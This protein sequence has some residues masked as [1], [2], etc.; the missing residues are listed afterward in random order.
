MSENLNLNTDLKTETDNKNTSTYNS[1]NYINDEKN[2][3]NNDDDN[4]KDESSNQNIDNEAV[5]SIAN[6]IVESM[7]VN[8]DADNADHSNNHYV[9][10]DNTINKNI[11]DDKIQNENDNDDNINNDSED[12]DF[13]FDQEALIK[14]LVGNAV[15][16]LENEVENDDND[17][18]NNNNNNNND[19]NDDENDDYNNVEKSRP[20]HLTERDVEEENFNSKDI[21]Q[22]KLD[23]ISQLQRNKIDQTGD[24][25]DLEQAI[26]DAFKQ[27]FDFENDEPPKEPLIYSDNRAEKN[28]LKGMSDELEVENNQEMNR[29]VNM[30]LMNAI[31]EA[32]E[33][34][35]GGIENS[36]EKASNKLHVENQ[37]RITHNNSIEERDNTDTMMSLNKGIQNS[38]GF[39][40][41]EGNLEISNN[42]NINGIDSEITESIHNSRN[43][44][45]VKINLNAEDELNAA[46]ADALKNTQHALEG[47]TDGNVNNFITSQ[48]VNLESFYADMHSLVKEAVSETQNDNVPIKK[49]NQFHSKNFDNN[50]LA[51]VIQDINLNDVMANALK[52]TEKLNDNLANN[53][54]NNV[55]KEALLSVPTT[56]KKLNKKST[57]KKRSS[58]ILLPEK[59]KINK[60]DKR[61]TVNNDISNELTKVINSA[62][63]DTGLTHH[64]SKDL[65]TE[66]VDDFEFEN[67]LK[68]V[69]NGVIEHNLAE[70]GNQEVIQQELEDSS[71]DID[72][73]DYNWDAIMDNAFE[74]AME[75]PEDLQISVGHDDEVVN[76]TKRNDNNEITNNNINDNDNADNN[77]YHNE[78]NENFNANINNLNNQPITYIS[79]P[80][81]D[82]LQGNIK[83]QKPKS[84]DLQE[85]EKIPIVETVTKMLE[86]IDLQSVNITDILKLKS[87]HLDLVKRNTAS[88][89]SN[90]ISSKFRN[91][92][93]E[94]PSVLMDDK[95]KQRFENRERKKKWREFNIERNRDID[96]K[97]RVI[98]RANLLYPNPEHE[99]LRNE[100]ISIE[101]DKRKQRRLLREHK[102]DLSLFNLQS[103][104][105]KDALPF[106]E[107]LGNQ[108]NIKKIVQLYNEM[109]GD[110]SES[111]LLS[112]SSDKN[113]AITSIA[114]V[115][116][117]AQLLR[118]EHKKINND[119]IYSIIQSLVLS[120]DRYFISKNSNEEYIPLSRLGE[121]D[122]TQLVKMHHWNVP[123]TDL[124][125]VNGI[126]KKSSQSSATKSSHLI[127]KPDHD[128]SSSLQVLQM[129]PLRTAPASGGL[130]FKVQSQ[131]TEEMQIHPPSYAADIDL[132]KMIKE[133]LTSVN[134]P[135]KVNKNN[136]IKS[137][138]PA[139]ITK[140]IKPKRIEKPRRRPPPPP[141]KVNFEKFLLPQPPPES[142]LKS[143]NIDV[144][145]DFET[146][147]LDSEKQKVNSGDTLREEDDLSTKTKELNISHNSELLDS[148]L[149]VDFEN[150]L[151]IVDDV[152]DALNNIDGGKNK[153]D[154]LNLRQQNRNI[155][156]AAM[157]TTVGNNKLEDEKNEEQDKSHYSSPKTNIN[158]KEI[159]VKDRIKTSRIRKGKVSK[160]LSST[161]KAAIIPTI[162]LPHYGMP[163][164]IKS[165]SGTA[166]KVPSLAKRINEEKISN[167][168]GIRRPGAFRRPS[169]FKTPSDTIKNNIVRPFGGIP[170]IKRL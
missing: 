41:D 169:A 78:R 164:G 115:L 35:L 42:K 53:E 47:K 160:A 7:Y 161:T 48:N 156:T 121:V 32:L 158:Y 58:K 20:I 60:F 16:S 31:N 118:K 120:L 52:E 166:K 93:E 4:Y 130:L 127:P 154:A 51:N 133:R 45:N 159:K 73:N 72:K 131:N 138:I 17:N 27:Q 104:T 107:F 170:S 90:L 129:K 95:E 38:I 37:Q 140:V 12:F 84:V 19:E 116:T 74:L 145:T 126:K 132:S 79:K 117:V 153:T 114:V 87:T 26:A 34:N 29:D 1:N 122:P 8:E 46:I 33:E 152:P 28:N 24:N 148:K 155:K 123:L 49:T 83:K 5:F 3:N 55:I 102:R 30:D 91:V 151:P 157:L 25:A 56:K 128:G 21:Q 64:K 40:L 146:L 150:E 57:D 167:N 103:F 9:H 100:W 10:N 43:N 101:F 96:L 65:Q 6:S 77:N 143:N 125:F 113:A 89:L 119:A 61:K 147:E 110:I 80:M 134:I 54:L 149:D 162:P 108:E 141:I 75:L 144:Q 39:A 70:D 15:Q 11:N 109:G 59:K 98:K 36:D 136:N 94:K 68:D 112:L 62:L 168:G 137:V 97:T 2:N 63:K 50:D 99:E 22:Q 124:S 135:I 86:C 92:K 82:S 44:D 71:K 88:I 85:S 163:S 23:N 69:V 106:D 13:G 165:Y 18:N 66:L 67:A 142:L 14:N 76:D 81:N 105:S 111:K 139:P